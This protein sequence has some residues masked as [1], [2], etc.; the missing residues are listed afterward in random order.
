MPEL[1]ATPG[2]EAVSTPLQPIAIIV[3]SES[4][5]EVHTLQAG[6]AAVTVDNFPSEFNVR[7]DLIDGRDN[8]GS[9]C[10]TTIFKDTDGEVVNTESHRERLEEYFL[11]DK[12]NQF[13][14]E[15]LE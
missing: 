15:N 2:P 11:C 14:S 1:L 6:D 4:N 5:A 8:P 9:V 12:K 7:V 13:N 3:D 10:F